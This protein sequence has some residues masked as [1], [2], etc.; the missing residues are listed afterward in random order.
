LTPVGE[1]VFRIGDDTSPERLRFSQ[2]VR[3]QALCAN[4]SGSD[5][6]CFFVP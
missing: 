2:V 4:L 5:Y 3:G 1:G 6:Y